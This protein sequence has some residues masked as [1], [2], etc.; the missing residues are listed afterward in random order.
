MNTKTTLKVCFWEI[1]SHL[2]ELKHEVLGGYHSGRRAKLKSDGAE[3]GGG[4]G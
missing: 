1:R 3:P 4:G 2:V